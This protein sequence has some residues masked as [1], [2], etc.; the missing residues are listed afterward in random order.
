MGRKEGIYFDKPVKLP[1][2]GCF[3]KET[4]ICRTK[5]EMRHELDQLRE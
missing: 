2:Q 3:K 1:E 5:D 4:D